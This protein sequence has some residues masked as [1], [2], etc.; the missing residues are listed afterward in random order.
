[1]KK[2]SDEIENEDNVERFQ[3][4]PFSNNVANVV[5][6]GQ[7]WKTRGVISLKEGESIIGCAVLRP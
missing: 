3:W 4:N 5:Q 2:K 7:V 6:Q 1:M